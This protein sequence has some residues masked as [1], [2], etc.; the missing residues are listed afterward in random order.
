[1]SKA[2]QGDRKYGSQYWLQ[3]V[4]ND[5]PK[6]INS[7]IHKA[8]APDV[9]DGIEWVSPLRNKDFKAYKDSAFLNELGLKNLNEKLAA[10]WPKGGPVWDGLAKAGEDSYLLVEAK[11]HIHEVNSPPC[12]AGEKSVAKI[13]KAFDEVRKKLKVPKTVPNWENLFYQYANRVAHLHFLRREKV[14]AF[15]VNVYFCNDCRDGVLS[16]RNQQEW[17]PALKLMKLVL[18]LNHTVYSKYSADVFIDVK[19]LEKK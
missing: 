11:S 2:D 14:N 3:Q 7:A 10:F 5:K 17:E 15:L 19:K 16:P 8:L 1:M 13:Q 4:V 6:V 9:Y 12:G 18:G